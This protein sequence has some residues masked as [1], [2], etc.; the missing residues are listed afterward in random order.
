[1]PTVK[2]SLLRSLADQ[3]SSAESLVS[4][5]FAATALCSCSPLAFLR[6]YACSHRASVSRLSLYGVTPL[7]ATV[8]LEIC[9]VLCALAGGPEHWV[10]HALHPLLSNSEH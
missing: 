5:P 1:M 8:P 10:P 2:A 7:A 9:C 4:P 3:S 6:P